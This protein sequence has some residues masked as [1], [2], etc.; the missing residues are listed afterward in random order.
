M[1]IGT[2]KL[3]ADQTRA[4]GQSRSRRAGVRLAS[5]SSSLP[6]VPGTSTCVC[7]GEVVPRRELM[8]AE[9]GSVCPTCFAEAEDA[10]MQAALP[11]LR[12]RLAESLL[13]VGPLWVW[14]AMV[15]ALLVEV[16]GGG[17]A[18]SGVGGEDL[19]A[20]AAAVSVPAFFAAL[21]AVGTLRDVARGLR[22]TEGSEPFRAAVVGVWL[23]LPMVTTLCLA[24]VPMGVWLA[25]GRPG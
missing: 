3:A 20:F 4:A 18:P 21:L 12:Q 11:G 8:V 22:E 1:T 10:A 7:C 23:L 9:D 15:A 17:E 16:L 6:V 13:L 25:A 14:V 24:W 5:G 2:G 19:V